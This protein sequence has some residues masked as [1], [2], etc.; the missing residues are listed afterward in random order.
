MVSG[1]QKYL[2]FVN[3]LLRPLHFLNKYGEI[4]FYKDIISYGSLKDP[5][6]SR[7]KKRIKKEGRAGGSFAGERTGGME[8]R[9]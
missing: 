6:L 4:M 8:G 1:S 3:G 9:K 7:K 5:Q 2:I